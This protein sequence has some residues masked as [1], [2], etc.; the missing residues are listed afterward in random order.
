VFEFDPDEGYNLIKALLLE[1]GNRLYADI[2]S[3]QPPFYTLMLRALFDR[4]GWSVENA[5]LLTLLFSSL[6]VLGL[7]DT[8]RT[9]AGH[10]GAVTSVALLALSSNYVPLSVSAMVGLP[11]IALAVLGIWLLTR[12]QIGGNDWLLPLS[13]ALVACSAATKLFTLFLVPLL[14]LVVVVAGWRRGGWRPAAVAGLVWTA[15]FGVAAALAFAPALESGALEQLL[16]THSASR[17]VTAAAGIGEFLRDDAFLFALAAVGV[18]AALTRA[19]STG[20]MFTGWLAL[21]VVGLLGHSPIWYH[22]ALLLTVPASALAGLGLSRL[23]SRSGD[24]PNLAGGL[25][26]LALLTTTILY[27]FPSRL[28]ELTAPLEWMSTPKALA[29]EEVLLPYREELRIMLTSRPIYAFRLGAAI[30]PN[31]AVTSIKRFITGHLRVEDILRA[32]RENRPEVVLLDRRWPPQ[33]RNRL[34]EAMGDD[35]T[36][37]YRSP[38]HEDTQVFVVGTLATTSADSR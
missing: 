32:F 34:V 17:A 22:H 36:L 23:V 35:Y 11:A 18:G 5:R 8:V 33:V 28:K 21:G 25:V 10:F 9:A 31:L 29:V 30:P 20:V 26:A 6:L 27:A 4:I 12:W 2:W 15:G 14:G 7:Y 38:E 19:I 37:V 16:D 3:D 1:Q 13:G 24:R